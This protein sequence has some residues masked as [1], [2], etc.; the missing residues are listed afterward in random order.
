MD[1]GSVTGY[2]PLSLGKKERVAKD[3]GF[4]AEQAVALQKVAHDELS[5]RVGISKLKAFKVEE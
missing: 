1:F 4:T 5:A 2:D 3:L